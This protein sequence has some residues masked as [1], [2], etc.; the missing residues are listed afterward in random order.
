MGKPLLGGAKEG[1]GTE[2][3]NQGTE[4]TIGW[5]PRRGGAKD[6]SA[7]SISGPVGQFGGRDGGAGSGMGKLG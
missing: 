7:Q 1:A 6:L 3:D 5:L 4:F 2:A